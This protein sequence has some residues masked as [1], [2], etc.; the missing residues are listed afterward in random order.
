MHA[1]N[2][3]LLA[4]GVALLAGAFPIDAQQKARQGK[5]AVSTAA[6]A[7]SPPPEVRLIY[8]REVFSYPLSQRRDP[9]APP[10]E[11]RG[12]GPRFEELS[13]H[14]VVFSDQDGGSVALISDASGRMY[15][16]RRGD[17]V[18]NSRIADIGAN[19]V[20]FVVD[21]FGV[22]RQDIL[23]LKGKKPEGAQG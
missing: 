11:E 21:N 18:G 13:L 7:N 5:A 6:E 19:R 1:R 12:A 17:S 16:V 20:M 8:E 10:S 2:A 14:G 9:F 3:T 22:V 4:A 23:E 15:R